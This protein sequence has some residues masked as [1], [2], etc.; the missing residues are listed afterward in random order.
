VAHVFFGGTGLSSSTSELGIGSV[1]W[2]KDDQTSPPD[3]KHALERD[4]SRPGE[5]KP[6][7]SS[8]VQLD[9]R[10]VGSS[11]NA[12][13]IALPNT[14]GDTTEST[15][16]GV[17]DLEEDDESLAG[18]SE[19]SAGSPIVGF[20]SMQPSSVTASMKTFQSSNPGMPF[21]SSSDEN[22]KPEDGIVEQAS[23]E[24]TSGAASGFAVGQLE[25]S[26]SAGAVGH[27]LCV[28]LKDG[29]F[30]AWHGHVDIFQIALSNV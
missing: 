12:A 4:L 9:H 13:L 17:E 7:F 24:A 6:Q 27:S 2:Q 5:R 1:D 18:T 8:F 10:E 16:P 14:Q 19:E 29:F 25:E 21:E 11:T 20:P 3:F 15:A 22:L 28:S 26:R 23:G 30:V